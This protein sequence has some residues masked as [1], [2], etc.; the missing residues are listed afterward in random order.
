MSKIPT[1]DDL[2]IPDPTY[3]STFAPFT[4]MTQITDKQNIDYVVEH[5]G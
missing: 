1:I 5:L 4:D 2:S 3:T